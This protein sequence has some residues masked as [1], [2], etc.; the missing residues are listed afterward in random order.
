MAARPSPGSPA[1]SSCVANPP[2]AKATS[3][4]AARSSTSRPTSRAVALIDPPAL[5]AG[6][7][8]AVEHFLTRL[9]SGQPFMPLTTL[10]LG[11]D[12]QELLEA[13]LRAANEGA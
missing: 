9:A 4:P 1:P 12:T 10:T 11:R 8:N 5:P 3:P 7:R 2:V 6:E 13:G